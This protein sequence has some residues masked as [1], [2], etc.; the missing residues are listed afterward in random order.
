MEDVHGTDEADSHDEDA[1]AAGDSEDLEESEDARG[2]RDDADDERGGR[3]R[4]RRRGGRGEDAPQESAEEGEDE[5]RA[6]T[7]PRRPLRR[8]DRMIPVPTPGGE[9]HGQRVAVLVDVA[10]LLEQARSHGGELAFGKL[11]QHLARRRHL[12]RAIAY[13][14]P[15]LLVEVG[16][17]LRGSD[18][19]VHGI[20]APSDLPVALAVDAM[21]LAARVDCVVLAPAVDNLAPLAAA[22]RAHGVRIETASFT[23]AHGMADDLATARHALGAESLFVP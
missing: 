3:R 16:S 8:S 12:I 2:E 21:S 1:D 7:E 5:V 14:S 11:V 22:L 17:A 6:G 4:R 9:R 23:E 15:E 19:D 18:L 13:G 20:A 10:A